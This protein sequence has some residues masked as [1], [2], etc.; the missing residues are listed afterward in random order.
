MTGGT[1]S[2]QNGQV[3]IASVASQGEILAGTLDQTANINGQSFDTFGTIQISKQSRIDTSGEGGGTILIRGGR[4]VIDDSKISANIKTV[5]LGTGPYVGPSGAGIDIHVAQ[6]AIFD[7]GTVIE[8]NAGPVAHNHGSGGVRITAD[9]ITISG[10]PEILAIAETDLNST[11]FAGIRSNVEP[12]ST[13]ARSGDISL[14]A[15]SSIQI[16]DS[17]QIETKTGSAG[18]AGHIMLKASGDIALN[19]IAIVQSLSET[20]SGHAGNITFS[21]SQGNVSVTN[22]GVTSQADLGNAGNIKLDAPNGDIILDNGAAVFNRADGTGTLGGIQI[23][24]SNLLLDNNSFIVGNNFGNKVAGDTV[25]TLD[26]RFT[27]AGNSAIT[28]E[29]LGPAIAADLIVR[30]RDILITGRA[31]DGFT[32]LHAGTIS[33]GGGHYVCSQMISTWMAE[34]FQ[35]KVSRH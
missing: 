10:G 17:G 18:N 2:A 33:S 16:K 14:N 15:T 20:S 19:S 24:A 6:D 9:H 1:L 32:R 3:H 26:G 31:S 11:P 28:T 21:S 25:I 8:T 12:N 35:A 29:A 13:A 5:E 27:L 4:L 7:N 30:A 22:S 23:T 34:N